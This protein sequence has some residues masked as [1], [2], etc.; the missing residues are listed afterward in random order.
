M[1]KQEKNNDSN[2]INRVIQVILIIIIIILLLHNCSLIKKKNGNQNGKWNIIDI[3]CDDG[4]CSK[5]D[6]MIDC[7]HDDENSRCLVPNFV[8]K[9]KKDVLKW[10]SSLSNNIDVEF[11]LVEN[12]DYKDGVVLEQS[13]VGKSVKELIKGRK[14]IV[15]TIVN[16]GSLVD[17]NKDSQNDKCTLPNFIDK[18]LSDVE[19]WLDSIANNVKIKFVYVDSDKEAG[20]IV[21]QSIKS[22]API[23]ELINSDEVIIIYIS[24]GS[25]NNKSNNSNN[26]NQGSSN[27]PESNPG[28]DSETEPELEDD[29]YV[30]D[31]DKVKWH[32]DVNLNI[33][34]DSLKIS[35]VNGKIAPEST[36][37]YKFMVNNGT[38]YN[39][40]YKI[41]FNE[42]NEYNMNIKY[43]LKKGNT[44]LVDEYVSY[45]QLSINNMT[46]NSTKSE[47]Y[48]LEWKWVGDND[49]NDTAIGNS[50]KNSDI[51]YSLKINVEAESI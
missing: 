50:A 40:K 48:Y 9:S 19:K 27:I 31:N 45:N 15:I 42:E 23:K 12:P 39:L 6:K 43:K 46:L 29:F 7:L 20:T 51:K 34:E 3:K 37:T 24:K 14:K 16:N 4:K 17:C 26:S 18:K 13:I 33:F 32:D 11:K 41:S 21:N 25:K 1:S 47:T 36:G 49:L 35:K 8:G 2:I 30:S 5:D 38:K 28:S 22:G 44:Y 10:L